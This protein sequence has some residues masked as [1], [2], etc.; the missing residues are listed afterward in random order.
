MGTVVSLCVSPMVNLQIFIY[1]VKSIGNL[2]TAVH[3]VRCNIGAKRFRVQGIQYVGN[4]FP[5]RRIPGQLGLRKRREILV[6]IVDTGIDHGDHNPLS[7]I[8]ALPCIIP[9]DH[10]SVRHGI[11][12]HRIFRNIVHRLQNYFLYTVNLPDF[13]NDTVGHFRRHTV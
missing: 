9:A 3:V 13:V 8:A 6:I 4:G 2:G 7:G 12:R 5:C 1:I 11:W 10:L